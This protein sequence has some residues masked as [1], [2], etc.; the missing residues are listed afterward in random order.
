MDNIKLNSVSRSYLDAKGEKFS[1]LANASLSWNEGQSIAITGESGS[2][3][4]TLAR[5]MIGLERP[6]AGD[7]LINGERTMRWGFDR[8]R[9]ARGNIQAVFQD[10][11]GTLNPM[12]STYRNAEEALCNFTNLLMSERKKIILELMELV[13]LPKTL[14]DVPVKKLSGGEQRRI[15]LLRAL[16]VNPKFLILDEVTAGL[17]LISTEAVLQLL[18]MYQQSHD[19]AYLLITHDITIAARLCSKLIEIEHG[20]F[21]KEAVRS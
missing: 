8:W 14:L 4:S 16:S 3:K 18:E 7:V 1:A 6:S 5:L 15:A 2:G 19:C 21:I 20:T 11:S 10:A 9:K 13:G 12:R 17:D